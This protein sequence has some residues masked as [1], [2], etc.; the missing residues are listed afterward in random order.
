MEPRLV[1]GSGFLEN[2]VSDI[3]LQ[4]V[5]PARSVL[6]IAVF[7]QRCL[8][9]QAGVLALIANFQQILAVR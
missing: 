3:L 7:A 5:Q 4:Q 1:R 9:Y 8:L 6:P 2:P